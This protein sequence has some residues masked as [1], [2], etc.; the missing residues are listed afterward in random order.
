VL[1]FLSARPRTGASIGGISSARTFSACRRQSGFCNTRG[2]WE[3]RQITLSQEEKGHMGTTNAIASYI[4]ESRYADLPLEVVELS[5][6][7][8]LDSIAVALAGAE[9][10]AGRIVCRLVEELG[11]NRE[12]AVLGTSVR[13]SAVN[14]ALANG[15]LAH[16]LDFDDTWYTPGAHPSCT[17]VPV[18]VALCEKLRLSGK[19]AIL[20]YVLGVEVHGAVGA[21]A[22][23]RTPADT[24]WHGPGT[25]GVLGAVS[26]AA[27][28][29]GLDVEQ[30]EMALGIG[31][32]HAA[33]PLCYSGTMTKPLIA[34]NGA[35]N[36]IVSAMLAK[37]GLTAPDNIIERGHGFGD[38]FIGQ[39]NDVSE[40]I[41]RD[42]GVSYRMLSPGVHL[43]RYPACYASQWVLQET[44]ELVEENS[45]HCEEVKEIELRA[46][47]EGVVLNVPE[48]TTGLMAKFSW[49]FSIAAPIVDGKVDIDTY[50]DEKVADPRI[51]EVMAKVKILPNS[52]RPR[53]NVFPITVRLKDGR[54]YSREI[55][56][57]KGHVRD[58]FTDEEL[59]GKYRACAERILPPHQVDT[60]IDMILNL[61]MVD[62][63]T[64]LVNALTVTSENCNTGEA[65]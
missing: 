63:V 62:D 59:I 7:L 35:R 65:G 57:P 40:A 34:G 22:V 27:H 20:A 11:G 45:I 55:E 54:V 41:A 9:Q 43:K 39:G 46:P 30:T 10:P 4:A 31:I 38:T 60:S 16:A 44:L 42:L 47:T 56:Y 26:A 51:K 64:E 19:D 61:D 15:V 58:P 24:G 28:I 53:N 17:V 6:R 13:T 49:Q 8:I 14:A 12:A 29:L 52:D 48:P 2:H 3:S 25:F 21:S 50:T 33:G 23:E 36:G 37:G 18:V 5:K 1:E 32:A